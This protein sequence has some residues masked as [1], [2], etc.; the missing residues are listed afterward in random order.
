LE[1]LKGKDRK[2]KKDIRKEEGI[3]IVAHRTKKLVRALE[4]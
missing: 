2:G 1:K 3:D 4:I